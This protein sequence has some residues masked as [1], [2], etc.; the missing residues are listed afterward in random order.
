MLRDLARDDRKRSHS[1]SAV[2]RGV[3]TVNDQLT[4]RDMGNVNNVHVKY[5]YSEA[6]SAL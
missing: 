2:S 6:A 3:G 4:N 1:Q 5:V